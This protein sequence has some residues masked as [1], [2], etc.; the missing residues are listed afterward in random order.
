MTGRLQEHSTEQGIAKAMVEHQADP[1]TITGVSTPSKE[2]ETCKDA[3]HRELHAQHHI[4]I[5]AKE[6]DL[7]QNIRRKSQGNAEEELKLVSAH[8]DGKD[9]VY[10]NSEKE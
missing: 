2:D 10:L 6:G 7:L 3:P 1:G 8:S 5:T 4:P 9:S